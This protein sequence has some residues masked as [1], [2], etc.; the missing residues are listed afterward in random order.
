MTGLPL[1]QAIADLRAELTRALF[2]G[3]GEEVRFDVGPIELELGLELAASAQAKGEAK[4]VVVSFGATATGERTATHTVKLV[5]TPKHEG[6]NL[7]IAS[8]AAVT[9]ED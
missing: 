8:G 9:D 3:A 1:S 7:R 5:L 2:Q 6:G 4:W